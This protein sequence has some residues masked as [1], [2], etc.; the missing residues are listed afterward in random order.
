MQTSVASLSFSHLT[1]RRGGVCEND[2][3][4]VLKCDL[5]L[6]GGCLFFMKVN[7]CVRERDIIRILKYHKGYCES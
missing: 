6:R 7:E 3:L 2:T 4:Q 1:M 5:V